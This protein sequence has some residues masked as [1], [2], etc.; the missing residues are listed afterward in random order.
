MLA[1][2]LG[3]GRVH[4]EA[5]V[6]MDLDR[7][8]ESQ[9]K[10]DPDGQVVRST[11]TSTDTSK[12]SE[13]NAAVSVQ[14]NLP[15]ADAGAAANPAGTQDQRQDETTN[16]EIGKTVRT[17]VHDQAQIKR[18]SL[19]VVVDGTTQPGPDGKPLWQA[20]SA[21]ELA[22]ITRLVKS[23]VGFDEKRG[24]Q[25]QVESMRFASEDESVAAPPPGLLG[26]PLEK[27]D[28]LR[29]GQTLLV[30]LLALVALLVVFRPMIVRL[31]TLQVGHGGGVLLG[32]SGGSGAGFLGTEAA[33][34]QQ[35]VRL[36]DAPGAS[37][38]NPSGGGAMAGGATRAIG[39]PAAA[40]VEA[41]NMINLTNIEGQ[42]R[43]SS[44]RQLTELVDKHPDE[45]LAIVR[46]W[47]QQEAA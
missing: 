14:N 11:Q 17:I 10:Y 22:R 42:L 3:P 9:E 29:I 20:R 43:A 34:G 32:A 2:S 47:M 5:S 26:V 4:A 7:I 33:V 13:A 28:L 12:S 35:G 1:P 38:G 25:I 15:N 6:D 30:G 37:G 23:A 45:S 16:Y 8:N 39:G 18:I 46:T 31:T 36:L 21:D 41:D 44:L 24:D 40:E 19:A 27:A